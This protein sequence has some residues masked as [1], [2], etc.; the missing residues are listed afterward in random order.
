[1]AKNI[2][3]FRFYG[4]NQ[5]NQNYPTNLNSSAL[6]SGNVFSSYVPITNLGIQTLPGVKLYI[7]DANIPIIIGYSG[8]YEL[9]VDEYAKI[10]AIN[11]DSESMEFLNN[12]PNAYLIIDLIWEQEELKAQ[13]ITEE[14][15]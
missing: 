13:S 6:V 1:M 4:D 14:D 15:I 8:I 2:Q 3:Q 7:N 10:T 9:D 5:T 12:N 11:F